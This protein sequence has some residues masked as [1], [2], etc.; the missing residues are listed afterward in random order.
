MEKIMAKVEDRILEHNYD[1]IREY[2][3]PL[4]GWWVY[5][6]I[7]TVVWGIVYYLFFH[8]AFLGQ[9]QQQEYLTEFK[10]TGNQAELAAQKMKQMW[11]NIAY[12]QLNEPNDV[13]SGKTIFQKNCISCHGANGEGGIGPNLTDKFWI[14]GG[15]IQNVMT[16]IING[17]PEKGM[18]TWKPLLKPEE[19]QKVASFVLSLQGTNPANGKAPQ[20]NEWKQ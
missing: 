5:L 3:N 7:I 15:G 8:V 18:I 1:G 13:E 20:G 16:T 14:H 4:P 6:F 12:I 2:D 11:A 9:N 19:V 10:Q 17:V